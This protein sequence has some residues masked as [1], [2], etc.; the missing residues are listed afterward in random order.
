MDLSTVSGLALSI[1]AQGRLQVGSEVVVDE[2]RTRVFDELTPVYLDP[3]ACRGQ[4]V[5]YEM[6]NGV[7]ARKDSPRLAR[8]PVRYEL[9]LFPALKI[10]PEYVKTLGHIHLPESRSGIDHPEICEVVL[11]RAHFFF[12]KLDPDRASAAEAF[13]IEVSA[14]QKIIIPPGYDHLTINPGPGPMLFSDVVAL[15]VQGNYERIKAAGGAAYLEIERNGSAA[16]IPNPRHTSHP[17]LRQVG[18]MEFP[19]YHLTAEQSLYSAFVDT[20]AQDWEFLWRPELFQDIYPTLDS[21]F[22]L[23]RF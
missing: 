8:L 3:Q 15:G 2:Y 20:Q 7:Y 12:M 11:G 18:V 23:N 1:D 22:N 17:P 4:Q 6:F 5:A 21:I 9:T 16:F 14:G 10:G 19:E 13:F